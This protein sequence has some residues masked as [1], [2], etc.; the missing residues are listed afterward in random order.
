MGRHLEK[1]TPVGVP[2]LGALAK[3]CLTFDNQ[4]NRLKFPTFHIHRH[5][6]VSSLWGNTVY[7]L[8]NQGHSGDWV[9]REKCQEQK[10]FQ[11]R[12]LYM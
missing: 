8:D 6:D 11:T 9:V 3:A 12:G 2:F 5:I 1:H 4:D 7:I 10:D